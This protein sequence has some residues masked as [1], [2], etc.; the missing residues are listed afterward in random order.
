MTQQHGKPL[1]W[2][3]KK[4]EGHVF[5]TRRG[6]IPLKCPYCDTKHI[7]GITENWY[8]IMRYNP[9]IVFKR[10]QL[11]NDNFERGSYGIFIA[12]TYGLPIV[13]DD[14]PFDLL[15]ILEEAKLFKDDSGGIVDDENIG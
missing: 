1:Y 4:F 14:E 15:D 10:W 5:K 9:E 8:N 6:K 3:C 7:R 11:D 2:G 12:Q 13:A